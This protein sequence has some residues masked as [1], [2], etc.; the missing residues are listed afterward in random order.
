MAFT[1]NVIAGDKIQASWGNE[2]RNRTAQVFATVAERTSQWPNPPDGA[3]SY[4]ADTGWLW[5]KRPAPINWLVI[6]PP[7]EVY[8]S[9]SGWLGTLSQPTGGQFDLKSSGA[10]NLYGGAGVGANETKI[11]LGNAGQINTTANLGLVVRGVVPGN[12]YNQKS[13]AVVRLAGSAGQAGFSIQD[14]IVSQAIQ[15]HGYQIP[16]GP[17]GFH[18]INW[19]NSGHAGIWASNFTV[20][21]LASQ[22]DEVQPLDVDAVGIVERLHPVTF[23]QKPT[24]PLE[25]EDGRIGD[26]PPAPLTQVGLT[27]EDVAAQLPEAVVHSEGEPH[28]VDLLSLCALLTKAVQQLTD[29]VAALEGAAA[30]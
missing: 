8:S 14:D 15:L 1:P 5:V 27:A 29:R 11:I 25:Y 17:W 23:K 7:T 21:A 20:T 13:V 3:L 19:N 18:I 2:I 12:T 30:T 9:V 26:T 10:L 22:L 6:S 24:P 16:A 4:T 28:S